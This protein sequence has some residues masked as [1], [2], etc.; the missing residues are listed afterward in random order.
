MTIPTILR[1]ISNAVPTA[2]QGGVR[3]NPYNPTGVGTPRWK[4]GLNADG[5]ETAGRAVRDATIPH[6]AEITNPKEN[7]K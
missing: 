3:S 1:V 6:Y 4:T 5:R 2:L 7:V